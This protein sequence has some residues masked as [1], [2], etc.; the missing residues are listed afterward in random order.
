[1]NSARKIADRIAMLHMGKIVWS[2]TP[3]EIDNSDNKYVNQF[4]N[5]NANGPIQ[6]QP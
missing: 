6:M 3:N 2:G 4:I 1:M 5:G